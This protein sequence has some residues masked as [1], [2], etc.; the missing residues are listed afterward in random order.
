MRD[1]LPSNYEYKILKFEM[2]GATED[3]MKY[4]A[5]VRV[6]CQSEEGVK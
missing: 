6:N 1:I 2:G 4:T 5:E 3:N